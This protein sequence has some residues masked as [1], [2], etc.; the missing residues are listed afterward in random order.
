MKQ[1]ASR[2]WLTF[3]LIGLLIRPDIRGRVNSDLNPGAGIVSEQSL[4]AVPSCSGIFGV[5]RILYL[6]LNCL[7]EGEPQGISPSCRGITSAGISR[8]RTYSHR[9]N[10]EYLLNTL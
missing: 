5:L 6:L 4:R 7:M 3:R 2:A 8:S 10:G 9:E 1:A